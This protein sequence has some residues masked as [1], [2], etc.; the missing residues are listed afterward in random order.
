MSNYQLTAAPLGNFKWRFQKLNHV[1]CF[2]HPSSIEMGQTGGGLLY[3]A[4]LPLLEIPRS[5]PKDSIKGLIRISE[6]HLIMFLHFY[7]GSPLQFHYLVSSSI[8]QT[9][10]YRKCK[11]VAI[12]RSRSR[13]HEPSTRS[14]KTKI[15]IFRAPQNV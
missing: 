3:E 15:N 12:T 8:D 11:Y 14:R 2:C 1:L 5:H 4:S 10:N 9:D 6:N 7:S 13:Y